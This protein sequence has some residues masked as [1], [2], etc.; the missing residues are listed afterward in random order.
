MK[1]V[2]N[3]PEQ[4]KHTPRPWARRGEWIVRA[5]QEAEAAKNE[6]GY[7][8]GHYIARLVEPLGGPD[9]CKANGDLIAAAPELFARLQDLS[10]SVAEIMIDNAIA[11]EDDVA[12]SALQGM[13]N[14]A[15]AIIVKAG[16]AA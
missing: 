1:T 5:D 16:G 12:E 15:K 10:T 3:Q 9:V 13:L 8:S 4:S 2:T 14:N 6:Y 11:F 7:Q